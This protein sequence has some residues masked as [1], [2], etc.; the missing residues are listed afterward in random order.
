M[1]PIEGPQ[2]IGPQ[3]PVKPPP[4]PPIVG[5]QPIGPQ[6]PIPP[7]PPR[8]AMLMGPQPIAGP[9][10]IGPQ[11]PP[12]LTMPIAGPTGPLAPMLTKPAGPHPPGPHTAPAG[13]PRACKGMPAPSVPRCS[14]GVRARGTLVYTGAASS[15]EEGAGV[16]N[17][18]AATTGGVVE[19]A[20]VVEVVET[21]VPLT[22]GQEGQVQFVQSHT[23]PAQVGELPATL[24]VRFRGTSSARAIR[25][26]G[27]LGA[28]G[29]RGACK[30]RA[31]GAVGAWE[32][33]PSGACGGRWAYK[34]SVRK[35][36]AHNE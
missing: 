31:R 19:V 9:Q 32:A 20:G 4:K 25:L 36:A 10:P 34:E 33:R 16:R 14:T 13:P 11:A 17:R 18:S 6:P 12:R 30:A 2:P 24:R 35:I 29:G 22:P 21:R 3:A 27:T 15:V 26:A 5:P 8:L 7:K 28:C 1:P 23:S